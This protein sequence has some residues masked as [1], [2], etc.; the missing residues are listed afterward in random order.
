MHTDAATIRVRDIV[1]TYVI[2]AGVIP[3]QITID[4]VVQ[5]VLDLV[6]SGHD[7]NTAFITAACDAGWMPF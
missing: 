2:S 6:C 3:N 1:N 7:E 4:W 5:R